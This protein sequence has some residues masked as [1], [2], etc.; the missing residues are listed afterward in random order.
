VIPPRISRVRI[1]TAAHCFGPN[2]RLALFWPHGQ[3]RP[4]YFIAVKRDVRL[5]LVLLEGITA[6]RV[7][8]L[9]LAQRS[10]LAGDRAVLVGYAGGDKSP[11]VV[12]GSVVTPQLEGDDAGAPE[13]TVRTLL[14]NRVVGGYSGGPVVDRSGAL[15]G[16]VVRYRGFLNMGVAV[17]LPDIRLFLRE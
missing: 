10:P 7:P 6:I 13:G 4:I 16:I 12:V 2:D 8:Y 5:D 15:V 11:V 1:L 14:T 3:K 9:Q 17:G